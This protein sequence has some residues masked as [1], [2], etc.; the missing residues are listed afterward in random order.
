[1]KVFWGVLLFM[2]VIFV[3]EAQRVCSTTEYTQKLISSNPSLKNSYK[4]AEDQ[5]EAITKNSITLAARDTAAN[6]IIYIPVVIHIVYKTAD[7][8]LSTSQILS[9]L[10]V[11]NNDYGYSNA[12]KANTPAVF[13][14]LAADTRIRF[15]L[16]QVDPQGRR[17]TGIIRKYTNADA[18]SAQDAVKF[19]SQGGDDAWDS[20]HYLNIWVCKMFGRTLGYSSVPGGDAALDGV[21]IAYDVFGTEGN[22]RSPF[23]KGRTATH[24]VGHWLGLKHIW[25]DAICGSDDV[26]DTPTQQYYNYGCPSFPYVTNCSPDANGAMFMNFMDFTDDACMNIFTNGQK[27]RMRALFAKNNIRNSFLTSFACDSTLAQG[28][29]LP[30]DD[31][32]IVIVPVIPAKESFIVKVYPNPAQSTI[33]IECINATGAGVKTISIFNVLGRKV[34]TGQMGK[35]KI[36]VD[37]T[38]FSKGMY[39]LQVE[40][41]TN[42]LSTKIIKQ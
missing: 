14:K 39:I 2:Q 32:A 16:A 1:M 24:E 34:F 22:V 29:P 10:T 4:I 31:T 11:L 18:F 27:L 12:D 8:N 35:Q 13:A 28:G 23:N 26:D 17:T 37:I 33:N 21:V 19:S 40:D 5:I 36:S 41:G 20:K 6:E 7:V 25:G 30:P 42:R 3:A 9:Q 15:C 38:N